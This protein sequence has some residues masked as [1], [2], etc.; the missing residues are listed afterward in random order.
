VIHYGMSVNEA[1]QGFYDLNTLEVKPNAAV[2]I[3][4]DTQDPATRI[5][6]ALV[7]ESDVLRGKVNTQRRQLRQRDDEVATI[8]GVRGMVITTLLGAH[9]LQIGSKPVSERLPENFDEDEAQ[10]LVLDVLTPIF[11]LLEA[12][13]T[14]RAETVV[15]APAVLAGIGVVANRA[16]PTPMR[17]VNRAPERASS[18][19]VIDLLEGVNWSREIVVAGNVE[20]PWVGICGKLTPSGRFSIGGPKEVGYTVA[21]ALEDPNSTGGQQIR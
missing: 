9:G 7:E 5:T 8:G 1:R 10:E 20:Y 2:A 12:P 21:A 6:R 18:D 3:T 15:A 19:E 17:D 13:L 14:N 16:M 4:M 11:D